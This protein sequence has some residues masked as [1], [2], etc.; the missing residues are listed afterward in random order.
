[1][2]F[3]EG[4]SGLKLLRIAALGAFIPYSRKVIFSVNS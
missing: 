2:P 3:S 4:S 1:M